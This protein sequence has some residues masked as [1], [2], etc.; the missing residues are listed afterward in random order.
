MGKVQLVLQ[1]P[2]DSDEGQESHEEEAEAAGISD[3]RILGRSSR[4]PFVNDAISEF[5]GGGWRSDV[6]VV[7]AERLPVGAA[8]EQI[9][10]R[11]GGGVH[12]R[13]GIQSF[14]TLQECQHAQSQHRAF[15]QSLCEFKASIVLRTKKKQQK[16]AR[17]LFD[18]RRIAR[19]ARES[20]KS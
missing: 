16:T 20:K 5:G 4:L 17:A 2:D 18:T 3:R 10:K 1:L 7:E 15:K 6:D 13:H 14:D 8:D 12:G 19:R 9:P 11:S